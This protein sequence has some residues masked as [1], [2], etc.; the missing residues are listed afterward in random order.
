[1]DLPALPPLEPGD[2][3][4]GDLRLELAAFGAFHPVHKAPTYHFRMIHAATAEELGTIRLR[5][6]W[7][8]HIEM[9]AGH[10]GYAVHEGH[11][12]HRY[13]SRSVRLL[14]PLAHGLGLDPLWITCDPENVASRRSLE[15]AGACFIEIVN[16]PEDCIIHKSGHPQ[17][18]RYVLSS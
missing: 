2:L 4:D 6:G 3:R 18:C 14:I 5:V 15:L 9:Y 10:I 16:V 13:A 11:R 7:T 17:K 8:Q 1:M 12:G